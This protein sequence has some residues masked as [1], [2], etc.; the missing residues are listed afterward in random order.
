MVLFLKELGLLSELT[1]EG[2]DLLLGAW[3]PIFG[4]EKP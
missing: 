3:E 4:S 2:E 1:Q